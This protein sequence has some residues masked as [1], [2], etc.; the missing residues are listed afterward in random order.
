MNYEHEHGSSICLYNKKS[1][2]GL[3]WVGTYIKRHPWLAPTTN[4]F[5]VLSLGLL[6][7]FFSILGQ[8]PVFLATFGW[9]CV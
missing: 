8:H 2:T 1:A 7:Y 9:L 3:Y 4:N 5:A 6:E